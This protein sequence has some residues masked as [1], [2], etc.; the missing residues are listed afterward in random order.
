[1]TLRYERES[2]EF[3]AHECLTLFD[4]DIPL[5]SCVLDEGL[6]EEQAQAVLSY[7]YSLSRSSDWI[8]METGFERRKH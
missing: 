2:F 8:P 1:M 5:K 3:G 6:S 4:D 7:W